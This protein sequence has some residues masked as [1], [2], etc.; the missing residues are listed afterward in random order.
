MITYLIA[1]VI[2]LIPAAIAAS[3]G[4]SFFAWWCYGALLFIIALPHSILIKSDQYA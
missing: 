2:G 3:K 1:A 4:R